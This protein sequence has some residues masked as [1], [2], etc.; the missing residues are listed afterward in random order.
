MNFFEWSARIPFLVCSA[1]DHTAKTIET[2]VASHDILPTLI[3]LAGGDSNKLAIP[4]DGESVMELINQGENVERGAYSEY[5]AEGSVGP[6]IMIRRGKY[7][8]CYCPA[9]PD[10]LYDLESDPNELNNLADDN[11]FLVLKNSFFNEMHEYWD[12]EQFTKDVKQSQ[13]KRQLVDRA[14]R[15]GKF[16]S[17]DYQPQIDAKERFMR[18]HLDLNV[19]ETNNR[20][21]KPK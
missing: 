5:C 16:T 12:F 20:Y 13:A 2:P 4:I 6:M 18:N 10:Q 19:L 8:Y 21:P 11:E 3:D 17:W 7:K 1:E 15:K 14:N 9:D